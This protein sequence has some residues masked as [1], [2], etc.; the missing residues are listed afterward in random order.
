M[1]TRF[2]K[3]LYKKETVVYI[4]VTLRSINARFKEHIKSKGLDPR[5][6]SVVEFDHIVHPEINSLD[7]YQ[8]ERE[9]V[10]TLEQ[11]YIKDEINQGAHLLNISPGGEWGSQILFDL[12]KS[13][14]FQRYGSYDGFKKYRKLQQ[15]AKKWMYNWVTGRGTN[16]VKQW[17]QNWVRVKG[18]SKVK[19]WALTWARKKYKNKTKEWFHHWIRSRVEPP[20]RRWVHNWVVNKGINKVHRWCL[21]WVRC[22]SISKIRSWLYSWVRSKKPKK[23]QRWCRGWVKSRSEGKV[24]RW[25]H[26]WTINKKMRKTQRWLFNWRTNKGTPKI[27]KWLNHWIGSNVRYRN[28]LY[29]T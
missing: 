25:L 22:R 21:T 10:A 9:K 28:K 6:Y 4:G 14:F 1:I 23:V 24:K 17:S 5:L 15:K 11:K 19:W 18:A 2:Y 29:K 16:K 13:Y 3:I 26:N 12:E 20:C 8:T 7:V 27:K